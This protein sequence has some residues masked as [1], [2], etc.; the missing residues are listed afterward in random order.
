MPRRPAGMDN[1]I[2]DC[3]VLY[4][5][6][7]KSVVYNNSHWHLCHHHTQLTIVACCCVCIYLYSYG[8]HRSGG[9]GRA[10]VDIISQYGDERKK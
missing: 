3:A 8:Q 10:V 5:I 2:G 7:I 1:A 6:K 4:C 9:S